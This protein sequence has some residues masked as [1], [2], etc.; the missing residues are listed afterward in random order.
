M[1]KVWRSLIGYE[2]GWFIIPLLV[3]LALYAFVEYMGP[4]LAPS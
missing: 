3:V 2:L 4:A 1:G